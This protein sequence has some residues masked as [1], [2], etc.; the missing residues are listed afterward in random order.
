M[1]APKA[2]ERSPAAPA[3]AVSMETANAARGPPKVS[4]GREYMLTLKAA[5][6][7]KL[8]DMPHAASA[9]SG[10]AGMAAVAREITAATRQTRRRAG[11][12]PTPRP[13]HRSES[14]PPAK[15]PA[16]ART[17]GIQANHAA[18]TMVRCWASTKYSVVKLTQRL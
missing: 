4:R 15:P 9:A 2:G 1:S 17:G 6:A 7:K 8:S 11:A 12:G 16:A 18:C 14:Q 5:I 13:I 3:E 10:A